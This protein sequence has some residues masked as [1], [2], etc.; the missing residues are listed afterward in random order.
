MGQVTR[1]RFR[2][3]EIEKFMFQLKKQI[4][5][6]QLLAPSGL[7]LLILRFHFWGSKTPKTCSEAC[8]INKSCCY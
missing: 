6:I 5:I 3:R 4:T 8:D 2:G 7:G 1:G